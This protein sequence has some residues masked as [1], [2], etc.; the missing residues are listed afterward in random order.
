VKFKYV[1]IGSGPTS[2][3]AAYR[4]KELGETDFLVL[5]KEDY[6]GGLASSFVDDQGFTWDIGGHV[7]FSHYAYFDQLML[8][9]LGEEGWLHH[10]RESWVWMKHRFVPYPFQNNIRYLPK[11]AM[12]KCLQGMVNVH[13]MPLGKKPQNF[14][15]W[16]LSTF[17]EG[18]AQEFMLPYNFKVWGYDP[19]E[20]AYQWIGERVSVVDL[21]RVIQN[22]LFEQDDLSWGPNKTFQ[23][24]RYG[25]TGAIWQAVAKLIDLNKFLF[26][27]RVAQ[28]SAQDKT[29]TLSNGQ[30]IGYEHLLSTV[31]LDCFVNMVE[32]FPEYL[33]EEAQGLKHSSSHIVGIGLKG[34]PK[35]DLKTKCWMYFPE[36]DCPFY[37]VTVF[38]NYSPNHVPDPEQY[39]SL[40]TETSESPQ[41]PV[42]RGGLIEETIE[43]LLNTQLIDTREEVVS[44]WLYSAEYGYPTPSIDRDDI[45]KKVLP[46]LEQIEIYSRGR[47]GSW[48]YEVSNQDHSL[49]QGVEWVN[50]VV[51]GIPEVTYA[52]PEVANSNW[53]KQSLP[54][55]IS[56]KQ[57]AKSLE[58]L[59]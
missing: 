11:E 45:L 54:I 22:I 8:K 52:Y 18:V 15:E 42:D 28:V 36:S 58:A 35:P 40:M 14:K 34:Q 41:K 55:S 20:M 1:L 16:I 12:W 47:F 30:R 46:A 5:E 57:V 7:Q 17:G 43:G 26:Q 49:M 3:G 50:R 6:C 2:L 10:Q 48:K 19:E 25:G 31:P 38:S 51:L 24:P 9:A 21:Q 23:F 39:W 27:A 37:R 29:V 59:L 32:D 53:G 4:L 33:K 56:S 13:K 44:T